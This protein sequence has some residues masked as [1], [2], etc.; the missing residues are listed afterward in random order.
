MSYDHEGEGRCD[1]R[2]AERPRW[3]VV[4]DSGTVAAAEELRF[5]LGRFL[6]G[7]DQPGQVFAAIVAHGPILCKYD[8]ERERSAER[9]VSHA[10]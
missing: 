10:D 1:L 2:I 9:A 4:N 8:K 6:A 5:A 3:S 7:T